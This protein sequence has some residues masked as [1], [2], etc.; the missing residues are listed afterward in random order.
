MTLVKFIPAILVSIA[1]RES[2]YAIRRAIF[3]SATASIGTLLG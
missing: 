2:R 3:Y 1:V